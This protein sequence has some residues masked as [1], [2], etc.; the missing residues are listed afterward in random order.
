LKA[1]LLAIRHKHAAFGANDHFSRSILKEYNNAEEGKIHLS[2]YDRE[3]PLV[4]IAIPTWNRAKYLQIAVE[5]ASA[6]S[7]ANIEIVI[8]N[9]DSSDGTKEYLD[10]LTDPRVRVIHQ[11]TRAGLVGNWNTSLENSTG[12]YFMVLNDD[13]LLET[14]AIQCLV[15]RFQD[16]ERAGRSVAFVYG[17]LTYIDADGNILYKEK[18]APSL[19]STEDLLLKIFGYEHKILPC[20]LLWR[21]SDV[22]PGF[23]PEFKSAG[24]AAVWMTIA[25]RYGIVAHVSKPLARYRMANNFSNTFSSDKWIQENNNVL[26]LVIRELETNGTYSPTLPSRLQQAIKRHHLQTVANSI[27]MVSPSRFTVFKTFWSKF[28][29]FLSPYGLQVFAEN[30]VLLVIPSEAKAWLRLK[31][32]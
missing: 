7:Y 3:T 10:S 21:R 23:S 1:A 8:S 9:D 13:D 4:S 24:E 6:Q 15:D 31:L 25:I 12:E 27:K 30:M 32:R 17:G 11:T 26:A 14:D 18:N 20:S 16:E 19:E 5:S 29:L 2:K 28:H 22:L